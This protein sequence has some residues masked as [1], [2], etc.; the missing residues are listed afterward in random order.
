MNA[1]FYRKMHRHCQCKTEDRGQKTEDGGQMT[2]KKGFR[3]QVSGG[4]GAAGRYA[5]N[6]I[7][8]RA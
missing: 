8:K 4:S 2:A 6:L 3:F 7:N 1:V 5:A